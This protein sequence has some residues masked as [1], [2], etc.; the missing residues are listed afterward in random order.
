MRS[1]KR[2]VLLAV[3]L[4]VL[5]AIVAH[6]IWLGAMGDFLV[7]AEAPRKAD[8]AVVLAGGWTGNRVMK[9]GELV[10]DGFAPLALVDGPPH[11]YGIH[12]SELAIRYAAGRGFPAA[13]FE[14]LPMNVNSTDEEARVVVDAVKR[15]GWRT[16]LLVT[17]DYHTRR[18]MRIFSKHANG[19][20][21][22]PV[23]APDPFFSAHAWW[24]TRDGR[25]TAFF[26]WVKTVTEPLGL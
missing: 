7:K 23:A 3:V 4:A 9:G 26:E 17:S 24:K 16:V 2:K 10:R 19:V 21:F 8:G 1:G 18:A 15:R 14:A 6:P 25:K 5:A 12:E 13:Y 11:H 20:E 22:H